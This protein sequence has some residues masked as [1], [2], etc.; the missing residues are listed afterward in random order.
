MNFSQQ[1]LIRT[2]V[3][4]LKNLGFV[5]VTKDN[6]LKDAVYIYHLKRFLQ[7][8]LGQ[9]EK[10]DAEISKLLTLIEKKHV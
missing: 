8:E 10:K 4:K 2:G 3:A 5:N 9:F 1:N 7:S 6:I